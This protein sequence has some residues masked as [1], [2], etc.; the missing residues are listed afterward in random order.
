MAPQTRARGQ[1]A[2]E[3]VYHSSPAPTQQQL[4]FA[5][6]RKIVRRYGRN[7]NTPRRQQLGDRG[8]ERDGGPQP[9]KRDSS[10][11][12]STLTQMG[13]AQTTVVPDELE[14]HTA[15][16]TRRSKRRKTEGDCPSPSP[17]S[18]YHT[19]TLT[20]MSSSHPEWSFSKLDNAKAQIEDS[21]EENLDIVFGDDAQENMTGGNR[22]R[23]PSVVPQTPTNKRV[24][25]EIPSS[26]DSPITPMLAR[27]SQ[28]PNR[29][30]L[31]DK[32]TNVMSP[33]P[34]LSTTPKR[35]RTLVIED[36]YATTVTK[37][38]AS[39]VG[40][41]PINKRPTP[42]AKTVRF[43]TPHAAELKQEP[44]FSQAP[45]SLVL[46][47]AS[48]SVDEFEVATEAPE[49][50]S[51]LRRRKVS[52]RVIAD[53]EDEYDNLD[54]TDDQEDGEED[55]GNVGEETQLLVHGLLASSEKETSASACQE[56]SPNHTTGPP[57]QRITGPCKCNELDTVQ[58]SPPRRF[59]RSTRK[60]A[61]A[62]AQES[63]RDDDF[64][65]TPT[66]AKAPVATQGLESQRIPLSAIHAMGPQTDR[67][68]IF[69]SI[70]PEH[71]DQIVSGKKNHE[72]RSYRIPAVVT[73]M[74]IYVTAPVSELR[75]MARISAAKQPGEIKDEEGLGNAEFNRRRSGA[76][77]AYELLEVYRLNN[78]AS[79]DEMKEHGW[80][81]G[82]PQ[83]YNYVPPAVVGHLMANLRCSLSDREE[84]EDDVDRQS[85]VANESG[86]D[87][88]SSQLESHGP[89][90]TAT[91]SKEVTKQIMSEATQHRSSQEELTIVPSSQD[92]VPR[93][94]SSPR[95]QITGLPPPARL[96]NTTPR[97]TVCPSQATTVSQLSTQESP[98]PRPVPRPMRHSSSSLFLQDT[99]D[100][101]SPIQ[102]PPADFQLHSSQ[103]LTKS[104]MLPESLMREDD[105]VEE[106]V[107]IV[108]D[109][110]REE[111]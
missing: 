8:I 100:D 67:S 69:I 54:E 52:E 95:P 92:D 97:H 62:C 36:S 85:I 82:P 71:V 34:K 29:S 108:Y 11:D 99:E 110:E 45:A 50:P 57:H 9:G 87:M 93:S 51:P 18:K 61:P 26:L 20:Q 22:T 42:T 78:P 59:L 90:E 64:E 104:Q 77:F 53:S 3:R 106:A 14:D 107:D 37:S 76:A 40:N 25:L 103:L 89:T 38:P 23:T 66:Q 105:E 84:D 41:Q 19:Q 68:D 81:A 2:P 4:R 7:T 44:G 31:K 24:R 111:G 83:K 5:P 109:S 65:T 102:L 88:P 72:F 75:Y 27:Y 86:A 33:L 91:I 101:D 32:S 17:K 10:P 46:G 48:A 60:N 63:T 30:P 35:P 21:E 13:W 55:Y 96:P 15:P 1:P 43:V 98:F 79:L 80:L 49:S 58:L 6:R 73:R 39:S 94:H 74:W 28:V 47:E 56:N 12:Q 16:S 70:H